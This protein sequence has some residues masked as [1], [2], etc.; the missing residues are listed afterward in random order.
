MVNDK[1]DGDSPHRTY[2]CRRI[3][4]LHIMSRQTTSRVIM[5]RPAAF[6][7][8]VETAE[9]NT[10]QHQP[11]QSTSD[12]S[13]LAIQEFDRM[14]DRLRQEGV[15]VMIVQDTPEPV[16]PD[17]VFPN[18]W[19][20][21]HE[22][23]TIVTYPMYAPLRRLERR[24]EIVEQVMRTFQVYQEIALERNESRNLFLEGTGSMVLDR[25]GRIAY[26]C[27]SP[28]TDKTLL[29]HWCRLLD[30]EPFSFEAILDGQPIYHTNVMMAI[31]DGIAVVC[32]DVVVGV[33]RDRLEASLH[34]SGRDVVVIDP[35]QVKS[36]AG[37][38]MA[39]RNQKGE[40][41]MA[42]SASA[43]QC[44]DA[45]QKATIERHA[46][47]ISLEVHHIETIGG[48]SVRCMIAEN[49]LPQI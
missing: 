43:S 45:A 38:M 34:A 33:D 24:D 25:E 10:F 19:I 29:E 40:Q 48:G 22:D 4:Q 49:F 1:H 28:R 32:L 18:N 17:A 2:F 6:G 46:R 35:G 12:W 37:N 26:A 31:G 36:F 9:N 7:F 3:R 27:I 23:G 39:L 11:D 44:L 5:V 13:A 47:I 20:S 15:D 42:M 16:K 14:V 8:N 21:F 30:Y 41:L